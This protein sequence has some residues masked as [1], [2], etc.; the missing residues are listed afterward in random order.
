MKSCKRL[1]IALI[2]FAMLLGGCTSQPTTPPP[3]VGTLEVDVSDAPTNA[4][5]SPRLFFMPW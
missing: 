3:Q 4:V 1:F 5:A 2:A